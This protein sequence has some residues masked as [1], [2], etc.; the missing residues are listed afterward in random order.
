MGAS[1]MKQRPNTVR[2]VFCVYIRMHG[3]RELWVNTNIQIQLIKKEF[4]QL[5]HRM[6]NVM[7]TI[8]LYLYYDC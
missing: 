8:N 3:K 6:F 4:N 1:Y 7:I 5:K 2:N